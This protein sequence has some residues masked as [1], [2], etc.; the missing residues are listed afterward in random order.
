MPACWHNQDCG[1]RLMRVAAPPANQ[2]IA[3]AAR[4][5]A[6]LRN[7]SRVVDHLDAY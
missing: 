6:Q 2:V 4:L 7:R 5:E 1:D 3:F